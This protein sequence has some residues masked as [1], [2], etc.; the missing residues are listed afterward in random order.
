MAKH[1]EGLG[2]EIVK[3]VL[4]GEIIEPITYEKVKAFCEDKGLEAT[5]SHM[6]V[7]LPNATENSHSPTYKKYFSRV[8]KGEYV[9]LPEYKNKQRYY[10]LNVDSNSYDWAFSNSNLGSTKEYSS[11]N[12]NGNKRKNENCFKNIGIGDL[13]VAYETGDLKAITTICKV[14]DKYEIDGEWFVEFEKTTDFDRYLSIESML[15]REELDECTAVRFH[16]GTLFELH[17][18]HF[19]VIREMLISLN[20][21]QSVEEALYKE[22]QESKKDSHS[23]EENDCAIV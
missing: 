15:E 9:V 11:L 12:P 7:I 16:R 19:K 3:G 13:V 22:V 14:T 17:E 4:A 20:D 8:G 2:Y 10:W 1:G 18:E 6:R 23:T 5:V 21:A